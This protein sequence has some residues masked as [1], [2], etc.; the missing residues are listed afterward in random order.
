MDMPAKTLHPLGL[1]K[2]DTLSKMMTR[3]SRSP[4]LGLQED[5]AS[6]LPPREMPPVQS[7]QSFKNDEPLTLDEKNDA[8][9][10]K[11]ITREF[12]SP[13]LGPQEK[14]AVDLPSEDMSP[15]QLRQSSGDEERLMSDKIEGSR[16]KPSPEPADPHDLTQGEV[17]EI[18]ADLEPPENPPE[19]SSKVCNYASLSRLTVRR[20]EKPDASALKRDVRN[21]LNQMS[22]PPEEFDESQINSDETFLRSIKDHILDLDKFVA[23]SFQNAYPAWEELLAESK[24]QSS[25]KV[26]KWIREGVRPIFEGVA[27]TEPSKLKR[28][29]GLLRHAVP[30]QQVEAY[31]KGEL[32]HQ[33]A[34][35]NHRSFYTHWPFAVDAVEKLVI[36]ETAHL[37]GPTEGRPK[38]INPLGVALNADKERLVLNGMYINSFMQQLP[39]R[40]ERLRD[41]L[42]FL[43][44]GGF[45]ASW[46][47]KSGYF[48]VV[49]HPKFRTYFG[50]QVG[51][52]YLHFNGVCFGWAQACYIFTVVMQEIFME[53]RERSI[54][55]SSY[56]DDG[57]TVDPQR[58]RCLW[59][60][61][62]IVKLLNLLGAYF[63]LPKCHFWPSQEGE[64]L[65]FEVISTDSEEIFRVSD[66]K[67]EKV[68]EVLNQCL[69]SEVISP[70][71]LAALAGKLISMAP[72]V[73][74][75]L[76]YNRGH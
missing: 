55:V 60:V 49:I 52:A 15:A 34:F 20:H 33:I 10:S 26:L 37:Y 8:T 18:D 23:G 43:K 27:N 30:P 36:T 64:W 3:E 16:L 74:P 62:L 35:K 5:E 67:M 21:V 14:E 41:I 53:V 25:R 19:A 9:L 59:S 32:P 51:D 68:K 63:G 66:W 17:L 72:A 22:T 38:V 61:V 2:A 46:D 28:V 6:G 71:Q 29:R 4:P 12:R 58:D 39:F 48:H 40:Y 7:R 47:L 75:A 1:P 50:F 70:R 31:L 65:G 24:R 13:P 57:I 45:I 54:P 69:E 11:M 56:I 73:L 76:I 44:K 42:T